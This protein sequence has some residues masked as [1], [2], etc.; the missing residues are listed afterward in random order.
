MDKKLYKS[1]LW[2]KR[3][4]YHKKYKEPLCVE[5]LKERKI[6]PAKVADHIIPC[7]NADEFLTNPIQSLCQF[8]HLSKT[9][10]EDYPEKKK[11]RL[12]EIQFF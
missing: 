12:T 7:D 2:Q 10:L 9:F 8:C 11:K 5:C 4:N 1:R 6:T 3:A